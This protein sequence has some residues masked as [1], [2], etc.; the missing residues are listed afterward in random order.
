MT[1][2]LTL[3]PLSLKPSAR[4][5]TIRSKTPPPHS[6]QR[7]TS[8]QRR[9][10]STTLV[11]RAHLINRDLSPRDSIAFREGSTGGLD[12]DLTWTWTSPR[13]S[14]LYFSRFFRRKR[15]SSRA[16]GDGPSAIHEMCCTASCGSF[17]HERRGKIFRRAIRRT[18]RA[19]VGFR[20]GAR[21]HV[22]EDPSHARRA[23]AS[24]RKAGPD[25]GFHRRDPRRCKKGGPSRWANSTAASRPRS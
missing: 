7:P 24:S 21:W 22:G 14:G 2:S 15:R 19:T 1:C 23:P 4:L 17:A 9:A 25:R 10:S 8:Q 12:S 11:T 16:S 18:R 13:S 5:A 3:A 20:A 6:P